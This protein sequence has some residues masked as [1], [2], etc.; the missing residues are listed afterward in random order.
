M[1]WSVPQFGELAELPHES[2]VDR[3]VFSSDGELLASGLRNSTVAIWDVT[4]RACCIPGPLTNAVT[5]L[6]FSPDAQSLV[7]AGDGR[8]V[9][10]A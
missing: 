6:V 8:H 5:G 1:L 2:S 7:S 9:E 10:S 4:E 3:I